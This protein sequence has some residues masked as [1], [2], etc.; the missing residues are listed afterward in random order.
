MEENK[1]EKL[2]TNPIE[3][4]GM[5]IKAFYDKFGKEASVALC[6]DLALI[7]SP[8]DDDQGPDS[9]SAYIYR[10]DG[11]SWVEDEKLTRFTGAL[12]RFG[13]SVA[14]ES[15]LAVVGAP[16][17][18]AVTGLAGAAYV[19]RYNGTSWVLEQTLFA[20][21]GEMD[22]H[23]GTSVSVSGDVIV[24]VQRNQ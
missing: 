23:F 14:L 16:L 12:S 13:H 21:D 1:T 19:F 15:E 20:S 8:F 10:Y 22:D 7:G 9:G 18:S 11:C 4:Q 2:P 5:L 6:G 17:A 3:A 24:I